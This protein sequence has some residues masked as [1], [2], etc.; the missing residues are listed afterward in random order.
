VAEWVEVAGERRMDAVHL[1]SGGRDLAALYLYGFAVE[2]FAKALIL[3]RGKGARNHHHLMDL[4]QTAGIS[5]LN[6]SAD[7]RK[8]AETHVVAIRY[9]ANLPPEATEAGV[10]SA[11]R[12][13]Q[14][15]EKRVQRLIDRRNQRKRG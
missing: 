14:M 6:L 4:M 12:L 15:L 9:Q 3:A 10:D 1:K 2:C 13:S 8:F 5:R 11:E 7:T